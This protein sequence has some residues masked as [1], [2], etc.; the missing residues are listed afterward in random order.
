MP[1]EGCLDN[2]ALHTASPSVNEPHFRESCRGRRGHV[3]V[4]DRRNVSRRK[5][6]EIEFSLDRNFMHQENFQ[7]SDL[8]ASDC[9]EICNLQSEICNF[10]VVN[11]RQ[12]RPF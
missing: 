5:R 2:A 6:M 7:N 8:Q 1:I 9:P 12:S 4:D 11:T 10:T 3:L